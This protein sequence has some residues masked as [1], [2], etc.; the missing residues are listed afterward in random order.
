M[1]LSNCYQLINNIT[2]FYIADLVNSSLMPVKPFP[3]PPEQ[4]PAFEV[5][6]FVPTDGASSNPYVSYIN[7]L[8]VYPKNLKYDSQKSF[9]KVGNKVMVLSAISN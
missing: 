5:E 6:E 2:L 7:H 9:T 8:Y 3:D 1:H 4:L